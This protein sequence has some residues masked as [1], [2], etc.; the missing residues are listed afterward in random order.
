MLGSTHSLTGLDRRQRCRGCDA[1]CH[2]A[3]GLESWEAGEGPPATCAGR[4]AVSHPA[5]VR[6]VQVGS[7]RFELRQ[8]FARETMVYGRPANKIIQG[9]VNVQR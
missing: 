4:L 9:K 2:T 3:Q 5:C 7:W 1:I 8:A 6:N